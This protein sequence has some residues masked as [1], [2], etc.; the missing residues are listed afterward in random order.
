MAAIQTTPRELALLSRV[1]AARLEEGDLHEL[2]AYLNSRTSHRFTGVYAFEPGLVVS[3]ALFDRTEPAVRLGANVKM[4]ESYCWLTGL[5]GGYIIEDACTD[6]RLQGH[7]ARDVVRSYM[8]VL[9]RDRQGAPWG[10]L[11]HYDFEP[12][13]ACADTLAMLESFRPLIEEMFVRDTPAQWAPDAPSAPRMT[14]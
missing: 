5:G 2:L 3:V 6:A 14:Q 12:R 13:A 9:L 1:F 10:T 4:K 8:A 11:C 7:A